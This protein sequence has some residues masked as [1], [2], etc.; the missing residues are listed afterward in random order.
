MASRSSLLILRKKKEAL[1]NLRYLLDYS[2][3][4]ERYIHDE[5]S[6]FYYYRFLFYRL[7]FRREHTCTWVDTRNNKEPHYNNIE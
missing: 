6:I 5:N 2:Q 7:K 3:I 4:M 1:H